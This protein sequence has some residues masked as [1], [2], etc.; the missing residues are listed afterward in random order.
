MDFPVTSSRPIEY[1]TSTN[2]WTTSEPSELTKPSNHWSHSRLSTADE[3][4]TPTNKFSSTITGISK[5]TSN[6]QDLSTPSNEFTLSTL[7][8]SQHTNS[9]P[10]D[11][12]TDRTESTIP[13]NQFM[14]NTSSSTES[15]KRQLTTTRPFTRSN[16]SYLPP[17]KPSKTR[18]PFTR[19]VGTSPSYGTV[20]YKS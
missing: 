15:S 1:T 3:S 2:Q 10:L 6:Q 19:T 20:T 8:T 11:Y 16:V 17:G 4:T 14:A 9:I 13:T 18:I 7:S 12:T 5:T